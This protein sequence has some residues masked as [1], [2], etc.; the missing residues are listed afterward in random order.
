MADEPKLTAVEQME[1]DIQKETAARQKA[2]ADL[3][4]AQDA[5]T[6][7]QTEAADAKKSLEAATAELATAKQQIAKL[8]EEGKSLAT[9]K[10]KADADAAAALELASKAEG[11][12]KLAEGVLARDP[13]ALRLVQLAG[14]K[15]LAGLDAKP[16]GSGKDN[17]LNAQWVAAMAAAG[18]DYVKARKDNPELYAKLVPGGVR[19]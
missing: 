10:S 2:E 15:P 3:K 1:A 7:A 11:R 16:E 13:D 12:A 19:K 5:A 6:A 18:G 17:S 4:T 14:T 8:E 9:A